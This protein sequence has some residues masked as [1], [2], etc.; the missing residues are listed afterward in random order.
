MKHRGKMMKKLCFATLTAAMMSSS[1]FA[2]DINPPE[3]AYEGPKDEYSPFV[4]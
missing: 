2:Q 3:D 4:D 1:A